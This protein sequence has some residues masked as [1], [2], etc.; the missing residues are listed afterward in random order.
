[1]NEDIIFFPIILIILYGLIQICLEEKQ[2]AKRDECQHT[3]LLRS[4]YHNVTTFD[5]YH[6]NMH[7]LFYYNIY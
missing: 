2:S 5:Y 3:A 1:M 7:K 4:L 6:V